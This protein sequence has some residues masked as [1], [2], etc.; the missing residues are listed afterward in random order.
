MPQEGTQPCPL[1]EDVG[2]T[3]DTVLKG[4]RN[5]PWFG[6]NAGNEILLATPRGYMVPVQMS[7]YLR[8][9]RSQRRTKRRVERRAVAF[10]EVDCYGPPFV[11]VRAGGL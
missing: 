1:G 4:L 6:E 11:L 10:A 7:N 5:M 2:E 9:V 3:A 8:P